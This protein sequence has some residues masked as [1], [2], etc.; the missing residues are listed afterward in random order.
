MSIGDRV[1]EIIEGSGISKSDLATR[2]DVSLAQLSHI[3]SGRNKPGL[4]IIQ[5]IL[6]QFPEISPEWLLNGQGT[7]SKQ[8]ANS[9]EIELLLYKT[10]QKLKEMQ[11]ELK[12]L[13]LEIREK[14]KL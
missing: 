3:T 13:E 4:E 14:R 10:E 5:K 7:K 9:Q 8:N 6:L 12:E 1:K 11:L 2:L